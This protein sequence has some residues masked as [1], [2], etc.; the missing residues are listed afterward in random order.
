M[1]SKQ[2]LLGFVPFHQRTWYV[3]LGSNFNNL[4]NVNPD[5]LPGLWAP[6]WFPEA[7]GKC[8]YLLLISK[9]K[10]HT[11]TVLRLLTRSCIIQISHWPWLLTLSLFTL[12]LPAK[13][14]FSAHGLWIKSSSAWNISSPQTWLSPT[15][16]LDHNS[17]IYSLRKPDHSSNVYSLWKPDHAQMSLLYKSFS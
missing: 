16:P 10:M 3:S 13:K 17:N 15:H 12:H 4:S 14:P 9:Y 1:N 2:P 8:C 7:T 6:R 5:K 11:R